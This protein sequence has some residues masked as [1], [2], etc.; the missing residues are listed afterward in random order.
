VSSGVCEATVFHHQPLTLEQL[1][2]VG[3]FDLVEAFDLV[4]AFDLSLKHLIWLE[5]IFIW[6]VW[7]GRH[8]C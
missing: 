7:L 1:C 2:F 6:G 4:G 8:D 3:A 5:E